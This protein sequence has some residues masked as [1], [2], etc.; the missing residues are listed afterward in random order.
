MSMQKVKVHRY[1]SGK[2]PDYAPASSSDEESDSEGFVEQQ[3]QKPYKSAP[4]RS[5][6]L[7]EIPDFS[8]NVDKDPRLKRLEK[9]S[10]IDSDDSDTERRLERHR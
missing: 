3:H 1:V 9:V 5:P 6:K 2:R 10:K 4:P 8:I 7:E